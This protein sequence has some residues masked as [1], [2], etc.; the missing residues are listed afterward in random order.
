[1]KAAL[2]QLKIGPVADGRHHVDNTR[3]MPF[4]GLAAFVGEPPNQESHIYTATGLTE[5]T[6]DTAGTIDAERLSNELGVQ[7]MVNGGRFWTMD[8]STTPGG[9]VVDFQGVKMA[10]VGKMT[11][12]QARAE[13]GET[14]VGAEIARDTIWTYQ[15]G[16]PVYL[17]RTPQGGVWWVNQEYTNDVDPTLTIDNLDQLGAKYKELPEGWT[18]ETKVLT[19]DLVLDT[20]RAGG[21]ASILRDELWGAPT[22]APDSTTARTTCPEP[23]TA[24][25]RRRHEY[26]DTRR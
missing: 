11:A 3:G 4:C 9:E 13:F 17:L 22:S 14:Y 18:F 8:A 12:E 24:R 21:V 1:M 26:S 7:C 23:R 2:E 10:W 20:S 16:K 5:V 19:E 15:A 6:P 25:A